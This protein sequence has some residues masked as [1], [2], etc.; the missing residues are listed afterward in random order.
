MKIKD[1]FILRDMGEFS[2]VVA[3]GDAVEKYN[4][5]ITLNST[6]VT[7]WKMLQKGAEKQEL[8]D[9]LLKEFKVEVNTANEHIDQ[10][11]AKLQKADILE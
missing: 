8:V 10:F 3:T 1:C 6:A 7:L 2:V 9:A 11:I 5:M 4:C